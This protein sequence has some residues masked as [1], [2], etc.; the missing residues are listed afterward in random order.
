MKAKKKKTKDQ[1][2]HY[3]FMTLGLKNR[4]AFS[5]TNA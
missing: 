3:I 1:K 4:K 5:S 2:I